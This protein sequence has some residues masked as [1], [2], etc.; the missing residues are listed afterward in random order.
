MQKTN[1]S[2]AFENSVLL[3]ILLPVELFQILY[4]P[5]YPQKSLDQLQ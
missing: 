1:F 3:G 5:L 2:P 4:G